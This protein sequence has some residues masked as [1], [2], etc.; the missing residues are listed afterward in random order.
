MNT[1]VFIDGENLRHRLAGVLKHHQRISDSQLLKK[2]DVRGLVEAVFPELQSLQ[3]RYY[4]TKVR[5]LG[6]QPR[7]RRK[8]LAIIQQKRAWNS[9][10]KQQQ[11]EYI[12]AGSLRLRPASYPKGAEYLVE[13]GVDV[14]LAV[15]M[16]IAGLKQG[17]SH[18]ILLSSDVD[19]LPAV[20]A[21]RAENVKVTYVAYESFI[22]PSLSQFSTNTR[23]FTDQQVLHSFDTCNVKGV[24]KK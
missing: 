12:E 16:M 8:T 4:G 13:K 19:L 3:I 21:L 24:N 5:L 10:L 20:Q 14:G 15:D 22:M 17:A 23:V 6:T 9:V 2:F 7:T 18:I 1:M 11:V